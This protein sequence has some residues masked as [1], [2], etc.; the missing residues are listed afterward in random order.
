MTPSPTPR[1]PVPAPLPALT[2]AFALTLTLT[3]LASIAATSAR[4]CTWDSDTE[5]GERRRNPTIAAAIEAA[6]APPPDP[7]PLRARI[8]R[9]GSAPR[10]DDPAWWNDLAGAHIRLGEADEARRLLEPLIARFPSD[11]GVHANL[12]TAYHILGRYADAE[13]LIAR[14]LEINPDAHFGLERWHLA[15]LQHLARDAAYQARHV[16]VDE[17]SEGLLDREPSAFVGVQASH[18]V[19]APG[20]RSRGDAPPA[21]RLRWN[22]ARDPKLVDGVAYMATL[23]ARQPAAWVALGIACLE[24]GHRNLAVLALERAARLGSPQAERL[25]A[26]TARLRAYIDAFLG[27]EVRAGRLR[28][29]LAVGSIAAAAGLSALVIL[30]RR[31]FRARSHAKA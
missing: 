21:Y 2:R 16:Y 29:G 25:E 23:N 20:A 7:A 10:E 19:L 4:A 24:E 15:L 6:D 9:L 22:L 31:R 1:V 3:P 5:E 13:R 17:W 18:G 27:Y 12:G 11:Y 30:L 14:D 8:A 28:T 26:L